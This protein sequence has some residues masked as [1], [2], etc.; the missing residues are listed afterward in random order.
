M[1]KWLCNKI[2]RWGQDYDK[3]DEAM[4]ASPITAGKPTRL[5]L[6]HI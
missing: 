1:I 6:I 3:P 2:V 4:Y 5:S